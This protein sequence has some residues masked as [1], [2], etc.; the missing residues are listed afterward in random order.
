MRE[1]MKDAI[2]KLQNPHEVQKSKY[3]V[4]KK[5]RKTILNMQHMMYE[6]V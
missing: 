6:T 2:F 4:K 3:Q 5:K 1:D